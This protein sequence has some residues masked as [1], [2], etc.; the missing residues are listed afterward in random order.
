MLCGLSPGYP[1]HPSSASGQETKSSCFGTRPSLFWQCGF[2]E[3]YLV[4]D[5][6]RVIIPHP[7]VALGSIGNLLAKDPMYFSSSEEVT[8]LR[9]RTGQGGMGGLSGH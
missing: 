1:T 3:T 4:F 5:T 7:L 6:L 9:N 8:D 2:G